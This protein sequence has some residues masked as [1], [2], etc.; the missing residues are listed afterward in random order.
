MRLSHMQFLVIT[1]ICLP[2]LLIF[3]SIII[4]P[5]FH[6][7]YNALSDL[8]HAT[9]SGAAPIFNLGLVIGGY[10]VSILSTKYMFSYDKGRAVILTY[11]GFMLILIGVYDEIYG[12]LHFIVSVMFF[13]GL[14]AYLLY[15]SV[16]EKTFIPGTIAILQIIMWYPHLFRDLPPGAAIP[17]LIAV[18]S[19]A[20]FYYSDYVKLNKELF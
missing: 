20:P 16:K 2:L 18:F 12:R 9:K 1:S 19:F 4:S 6:I 7:W 8:G 17:E 11:T 14:I 10:L 13:L 3:V 5:W 15:I